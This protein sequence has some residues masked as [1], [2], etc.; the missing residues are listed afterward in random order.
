MIGLLM[1]VSVVLRERKCQNL[2]WMPSKAFL[3]KQAKGR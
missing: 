2:Q 1:C 3:Q